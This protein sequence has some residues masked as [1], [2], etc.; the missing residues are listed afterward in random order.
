MQGEIEA[1]WERLDDN[2]IMY[3][4]SLPETLDYD[5]RLEDTYQ[6]VKKETSASGDNRQTIRLTLQTTAPIEAL[7]RGNA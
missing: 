3:S 6:I 7:G 4:V 2:G 1:Q 5:L